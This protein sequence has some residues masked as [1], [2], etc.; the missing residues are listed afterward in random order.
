MTY[1]VKEIF[2]TLQG[3]GA[4]TGRA[5]VFCRFAGS[6]SGR[7]ARKTG[8]E[9]SAAFAIR[10]LSVRTAKAAGDLR[11]PANLRR[12]CS[13]S[14]SRKKTKLFARSSS[15]PAENLFCRSM[16]NSS[17]S[18]ITLVLKL[19]WRRTVRRRRQM[20]LIGFA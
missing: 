11:L 16:K 17:K 18:F 9:P 14:G 19:P 15:A 2:Y 8:T 4:N 10:I 20:E 13:R 7:D 6:I 3:E 5:A 1:L 12:K